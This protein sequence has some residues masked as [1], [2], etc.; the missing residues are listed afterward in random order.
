MKISKQII[1][2]SLATCLTVSPLIVSANNEE[3]IMKLVPINAAVTNEEQ[4]EIMPEYV[5]YEGKIVELREVKTQTQ[6]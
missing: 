5:K 1:A 2:L 4:E 3:G 6:F